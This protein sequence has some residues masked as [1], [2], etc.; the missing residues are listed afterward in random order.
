MEIKLIVFY[1]YFLL[2]RKLMVNLMV[3]I[4]GGFHLLKRYLSRKKG[5][6][7]EMYKCQR[8]INLGGSTLT[9]NL[10]PWKKSASCFIWYWLTI[11]STLIHTFFFSLR[12]TLIHESYLSQNPG[13]I[14]ILILT[15]KLFIF[16]NQVAF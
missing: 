7:F 14:L 5:Q 15:I 3:H 1:F 8:H 9:I 11:T 12:N 16:E 6:P 2:L 10:I 13:G 4:W